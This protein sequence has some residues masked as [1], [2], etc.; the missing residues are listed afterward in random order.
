VLLGAAY[1][2]I[3]QPPSGVEETRLV[4]EARQGQEGDYG[5]GAAADDVCL[6]FDPGGPRST[7]GQRGAAGDQL[8]VPEQ[9]AGPRGCEG[10]ARP[11]A[12]EPKLRRSELPLS[13][14]ERMAH[15]CAGRPS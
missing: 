5:P 11:P 10:H 1:Q 12:V 13:S 9:T 15:G 4:E 7:A 8:S 6:A 3:P 2:R 14:G